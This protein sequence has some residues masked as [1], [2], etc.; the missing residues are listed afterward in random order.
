M[1]TPMQKTYL[2]LL[3]KTSLKFHSQAKTFNS[4]Q[5]ILYTT[6]IN[7][8]LFCFVTEFILVNVFYTVKKNF[9]QK[10]VT[11]ARY[12]MCSFASQGPFSRT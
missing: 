8:A 1:Y 7:Q 5:Y 10:T 2:A 6:Q 3:G 4:A 9:V 12:G 11:I